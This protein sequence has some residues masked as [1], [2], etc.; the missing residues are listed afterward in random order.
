MIE[1]YCDACGECFY[2]A[3]EVYDGDDFTC[4]D[5]GLTVSATVDEDGFLT[6]NT[7]DLNGEMI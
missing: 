4:P 7:F 2:S 5:C 6:W 3:E 1:A